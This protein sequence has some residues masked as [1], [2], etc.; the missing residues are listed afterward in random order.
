MHF[1]SFNTCNRL[2]YALIMVCYSLPPSLQI[3]VHGSP[4]KAAVFNLVM[5][6]FDNEPATL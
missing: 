2:S 3:Q 1:I 5:T 6:V 4:C